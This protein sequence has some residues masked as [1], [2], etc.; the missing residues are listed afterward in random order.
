[1]IPPQTLGTLAGIQQLLSELVENLSPRDC[2]RRFHPALPSMGWLLGRAVYLEL[3]LL[4]ERVMRDDD[5]SKRVQHLFAASSQ[6]VADVDE[7]LPPQEHLLNWALEIF[8][9][10][11]T[12]LANP[13]MLPSHPWLE[14][15]W[16]PAYLAQRHAQTY[17]QMLACLNARALQRDRGEYQVQQVLVAQLPQENTERIEQGHYR[18]GAREGVVMDCEQPFQTVELHAFRIGRSPVSNAEYLAFMQDGGYRCQ[19]WWDEAGWRWCSQ[20]ASAAP[21]HWR[22]DAT[23]NWF[24]IGI[25]GGLDL[26]P[27]EPVGGLSAH[28]ARAFAAWA[29][30]NGK[31]L[32]G[33]VPQHEYQW[34]VAARLGQL[35][36]TG[37]VWEWCAN[38]FHSYPAYQPPAEPELRSIDLDD[39]RVSLRGA[40]LHTQPSLRRASYRRGSLPACNTL[41][42]GTRLV[43]PPGKAAWE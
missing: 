41:F 36:D 12:L 22:Q 3:Y 4:R 24:G 27:L 9:H 10:H 15:G 25:N 37:R 16:L 2:N 28:E 5:L 29:S 39:D 1:M 32:S 34:E 13:G 17:E 8:D 6:D 7:Q 30:A 38:A 33:A 35:Q 18:I 20:Q 11:L 14:D 23:G 43:L 26:H 40:C 42:A 19:D 31:G 21:W